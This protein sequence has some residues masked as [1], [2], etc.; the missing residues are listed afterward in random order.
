MLTDLELPFIVHVLNYLYLNDISLS[1]YTYTKERGEILIKNWF[2]KF[3]IFSLQVSIC[4]IT[5]LIEIMAS[6]LSN[7][8]RQTCLSIYLQG[9]ICLVILPC[10]AQ[11]SSFQ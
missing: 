4:L 3:I 6:K 10:T 11:M 9:Q 7:C 1:G 5:E 2:E 8:D